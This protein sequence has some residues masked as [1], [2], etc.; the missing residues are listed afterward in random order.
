MSAAKKSRSGFLFMFI[1]IALLGIIIYAYRDKFSVLLNTAFSSGKDLIENKKAKKEN[2]KELFSEKIKL[3]DEVTKNREKI[4]K[5]LKNITEDFKKKDSTKNESSKS[6]VTDKKEM[7]EKITKNESSSK[8]SSVSS[9]KKS[10]ETKET[11]PHSR[12]S[13]V[14]F[15]TLGDDES[16]KLVS[17]P[18]TVTYTNT[19]LTETIRALLTGPSGEEKKNNLI[20][21]IPDNTKLL[22]VAVKDNIAYIN[23][24]KEFEFNSFGR[25]ATIGQIK[26]IVYT[27]TEFSNVRSVQFLING[28]VKTY[29]GGE[30]V[31]IS[32]PLSRSDFS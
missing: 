28:Q 27:V 2:D 30:G 29:L 16:I 25:E 10:V 12:K 20:T 3:L 11:A 21:N 15:S 14:Y 17:V 6:N 22:S 8:S 24:S 13:I 32:K 31:I 18:R 1:V 23:L 9:E 19:P 26:Q 5:D 4:E 7:S